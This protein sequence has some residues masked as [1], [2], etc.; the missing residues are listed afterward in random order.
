MEF[1]PC[2]GKFFLEMLYEHT[3]PNF[4]L[5]IDCYWAEYADQNCMDIIKKYK[6]KTTTYC[7]YKQMA[8]DSKANVT[9]YL[10]IVDFKAISYFL[11]EN[12]PNC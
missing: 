11:T 4:L 3:L 10:C 5:E 8:K 7:H 9:V 6:D 2:N 12:T 1:A